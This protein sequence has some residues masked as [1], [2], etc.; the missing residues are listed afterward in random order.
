MHAKTETLVK[1]PQIRLDISTCF[2]VAGGPAQGPLPAAA[3]SGK[4]LLPG[5]QR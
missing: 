2:C 4:C 3:S 5:Q 1:I